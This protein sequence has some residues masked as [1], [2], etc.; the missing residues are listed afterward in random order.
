MAAGR[1]AR[2][3]PR[4]E[5]APVTFPD[6]RE[7]RPVALGYSRPNHRPAGCMGA[8]AHRQSTR[9]VAQQ[10]RGLAAEGRRITERNEDAPPLAEQFP[11]VPIGCRDDRF[12]QA[13]A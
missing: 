3:L 10:S 8:L 12:T 9:L 1:A 5:V 4:S 2:V 7:D 13:E 11:C 6:A